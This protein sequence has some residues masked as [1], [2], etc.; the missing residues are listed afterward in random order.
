MT[1][2]NNKARRIY[3]PSKPAA[4]AASSSKAHSA[5]HAPIVHALWDEGVAADAGADAG[6]DADAAGDA[7]AGADA[8]PAQASAP[9]ADGANGGDSGVNSSDEYGD[10]D[11]DVPMDLENADSSDDDYGG[12][13][14]Y[15]GDDYSGDD[16]GDGSGE[17]RGD[18]GEAGGAQGIALG[19]G[20]P[21]P[22]PSERPELRAAC[23]GAPGPTTA[24]HRRAFYVLVVSV[25]CRSTH[26]AALDALLLLSVANGAQ[27]R[28]PPRLV[29]G[30][31][32]QASVRDFVDAFCALPALPPNVRTLALAARHSERFVV[33][34]YQAA[35]DLIKSTPEAEGTREAAVEVELDGFIVRDVNKD[36]ARVVQAVHTLTR[37]CGFVR[38]TCEQ[39]LLTN[40]FSLDAVAAAPSETRLEMSTYLLGHKSI[41]TTLNSV[42]DSFVEMLRAYA[43]QQGALSSALPAV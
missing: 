31:R 14:D 22:P 8:A 12:G 32:V 34:H 41:Y 19:G 28:V 16:D 20:A 33:N 26:T 3:M 27:T 29:D 6:A 7:G 40:E 5:H 18:A 43:L 21:L 2:L 30:L 25:L 10:Y 4:P 13:G 9:S 42:L 37:F 36:E 1:R 17:A 35:L 15:G 38:A 23:G 11:D 24:Q 39:E